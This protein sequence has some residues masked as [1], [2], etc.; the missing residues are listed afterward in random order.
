MLI[1]VSF[2]FISCSSDDGGNGF[3]NDLLCSLAN[4]KLQKF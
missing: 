4:G 1:L 2:G 3:D